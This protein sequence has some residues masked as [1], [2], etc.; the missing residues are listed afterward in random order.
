MKKKSAAATSRV[1]PERTI[2]Q[3]T[4]MFSAVIELTDRGYAVEHAR[5]LITGELT[6]LHGLLAMYPSPAFYACVEQ[7][8]AL[9]ERILHHLEQR[10]T[11][12]DGEPDEF[13]PAL[14]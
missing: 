14:N 9:N 5:E 7:R 11:E 13:R 6:S 2:V 1:S 4:E 12:L 3:H 10:L 8:F